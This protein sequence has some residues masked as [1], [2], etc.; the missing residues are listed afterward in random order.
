MGEDAAAD[1]QVKPQPLQKS[2][3]RSLRLGFAVLFIVWAVEPKSRR[4][5][6]WSWALRQRRE[7]YTE[8]LPRRPWVD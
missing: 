6:N 1:S 3:P 2:K 4:R 8:R 7:S 5:G